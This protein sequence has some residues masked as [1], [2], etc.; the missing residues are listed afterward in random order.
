[1]LLES[2]SACVMVTPVASPGIPAFRSAGCALTGHS[3]VGLY[4]ITLDGGGIAAAE[5]VEIATVRGAVSDADAHVEHVS[6][7]VKRIRTNVAG[8]PSDALGFSVSFARIPGGH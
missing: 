8:A 5:C 7:T 2:L 3:G 4:E 1:M 6:D